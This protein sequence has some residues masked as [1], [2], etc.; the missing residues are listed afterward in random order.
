MDTLE[1]RSILLGELQREIGPKLGESGG[2]KKNE[3]AT[4]EG[5]EPV[6]WWCVCTK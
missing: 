3:D 5:V 6:G 2:S 1:E 4:E